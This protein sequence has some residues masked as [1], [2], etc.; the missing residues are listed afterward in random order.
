MTYHQNQNTT[1]YYLFYYELI[2]EHVPSN[3]SLT[4]TTRCNFCVVQHTCLFLLCNN[5]FKNCKIAWAIFCGNLKL[6]LRV[7]Q[8]VFNC[9]FVIARDNLFHL[10][11][12]AFT[13]FTN[14]C[15]SV[16]A[17]QVYALV[18]ADHKTC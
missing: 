4:M 13:L 6:I 7:S 12:V 9:L 1:K 18:L 10:K 17:L 8:T 11:H 14:R 5:I 15:K 2:T 16:L 3:F